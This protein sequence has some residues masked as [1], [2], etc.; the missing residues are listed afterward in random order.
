MPQRYAL[1]HD[2]RNLEAASQPTTRLANPLLLFTDGAWHGGFWRVGFKLSS[3]VE[4]AAILQ[5]WDENKVKTRLATGVF[6][7]LVARV[8]GRN[9]KSH[10]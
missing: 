10:L 3:V 4:I 5:L 9:M 1:I 8:A 6:L 2:L 7:A